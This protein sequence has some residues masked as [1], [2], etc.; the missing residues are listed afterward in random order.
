MALWKTRDLPPARHSARCP[1]PC[2]ESSLPASCW[3]WRG[4][5]KPGASASPPVTRSVWQEVW[6]RRAWKGPDVGP[7]GVDLWASGTHPGGFTVRSC[8]SSGKFV[9]LRA[10]VSSPATGARPA[11]P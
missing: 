3:F 1:V 7:A 10:S 4:G 9:Q 11:H 6:D 5:V 2:P 8:R